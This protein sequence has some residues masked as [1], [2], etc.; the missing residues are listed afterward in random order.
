MVPCALIYANCLWECNS[1]SS[2]I[3][4]VPSSLVPTLLRG[5]EI[6]VHFTIGHQYRSAPFLP[7]LHT[8]ILLAISTVKEL[9][10]FVIVP[11]PI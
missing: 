2:R 5:N 3:S 11:K 9:I 8:T 1:L 7:Q 6:I 10:L 4:V